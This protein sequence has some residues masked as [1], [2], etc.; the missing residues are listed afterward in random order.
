MCVCTLCESAMQFDDLCPEGMSEYD[1]YMIAKYQ[2]ELDYLEYLD[3]CERFSD[4][5]E[6]DP[7]EH[8]VMLRL[9]RGA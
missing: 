9:E 6:D 7:V 5:P 8:L 2:E 4:D 1:A 3:S